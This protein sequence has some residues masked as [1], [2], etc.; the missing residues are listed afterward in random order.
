MAI[1]LEKVPTPCPSLVLLL[2]IVGFCEVLQHTPRPVTRA[3]PSEM[4]FPP[5][6]A[7]VIE[8]LFTSEVVTTGKPLSS[9]CLQAVCANKMINS[10]IINKLYLFIMFIIELYRIF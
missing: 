9:S 10:A 1:L 5:E 8:I 3:F 6:E 7:D 2:A 4:T